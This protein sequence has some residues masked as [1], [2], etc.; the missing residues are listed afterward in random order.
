M[1]LPFLQSLVFAEAVSLR[2]HDAN[3]ASTQETGNT[4][5]QTS[6]KRIQ[7]SGIDCSSTLPP[8]DRVSG[9]ESHQTDLVNAL[10]NVK[11]QIDLL[12]AQSTKDPFI[13]RSLESLINFFDHNI[14]DLQSTIIRACAEAVHAKHPTFL[15]N[16]V[17]SARKSYLTDLL[18]LRC[19]IIRN[20]M[21][22]SDVDD[23]LTRQQ[24]DN[25]HMEISASEFYLNIEHQFANIVG[26]RLRYFLRMLLNPQ[27]PRLCAKDTFYRSR[28]TFFSKVSNIVKLSLVS[29]GQ[30]NVALEDA[31]VSALVSKSLQHVY[32]FCG[33]DAFPISITEAETN[34]KVVFASFT[35]LPDISEDFCGR[36]ASK[37][38]LSK[39]P[40]FV[41]FDDDDISEIQND[42]QEATALIVAYKSARFLLDLFTCEKVQ[43]EINRLGGW[44]KLEDCA[45]L[46]R[47]FKL[48]HICDFDAHLVPLYNNIE[49][50]N[51]IQQ[52]CF[53]LEKHVDK[54]QS[55]L[56]ALSRRLGLRTRSK[57]LQNNYPQLLTVVE[58]FEE[59]NELINAIPV[60]E[61]RGPRKGGK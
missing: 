45:R 39:R 50:V 3:M 15:L 28:S 61:R 40:P 34:S 18:R 32:D 4:D 25:L 22:V 35:T 8:V 56:T 46:S 47:K 30:A 6:E 11:M 38:E 10:I 27:P 26:Q 20:R 51:R 17:N 52:I 58:T 33:V 53:Y 59:S 14:G 31:C 21:M 42:L 12:I 16:R 37:R 2:P 44:T 5:Y 49:F 29:N 19:R 1:L 24:D 9:S 54:C 48:W 55:S 13:L 41:H 60:V 7:F 36:P 43:K 23:T 57:L